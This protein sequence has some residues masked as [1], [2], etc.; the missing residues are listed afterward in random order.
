MLRICAFL[1]FCFLAVNADGSFYVL[2]APE[3]ISFQRIQTVL[4]SEQVGDVIKAARGCDVSDTADFPGLVINDP[5][6]LPQKAAVVDVIGLN[7]LPLSEENISYKID[8][9]SVPASLDDL[10]LTS[11]EDPS[12]CDINISNFKENE[13][14]NCVLKSNKEFV[15]AKIDVSSLKDDAEKSK[16]ISEF[17]NELVNLQR[18][19]E[20]DASSQS[21][22]AV[23]VSHEDDK[24]SNLSRRRRETIAGST[25][26]TYNLAAYYDQN[27]PVIFNI[28]LWFMVALG[29]SLLAVCYAIADMDP[30][31]DSIIYR[32]TSTRMKKDN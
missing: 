23:I 19:I 5:F 2:N 24:N 1:M 14:A 11:N 3:S 17:T 6:G 18:Q 27:Y 28:I 4:P 32:M 8:G 15:Y 16:V 13:L 29:L 9:K 26:N 31:R 22:L 12:D 10:K 21:L 30:G 25:T 20:G 7:E